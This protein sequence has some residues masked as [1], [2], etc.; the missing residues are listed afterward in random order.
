MGRMIILVAAS[1]YFPA[2]D[3][4]ERNLPY[5]LPVCVPGLFHKG[6][7]YSINHHLQ[8]TPLYNNHFLMCP[9]I[10]E[11]SLMFFTLVITSI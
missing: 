10:Q 7:H 2:I 4:F 11:C 1:P 9:V 5:L 6:E 8:T 3:Y